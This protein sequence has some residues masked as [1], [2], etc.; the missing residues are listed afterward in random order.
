MFVLVRKVCN[1]LKVHLAINEINILY[2]K[3][4]KPDFYQTKRS[5]FGLISLIESD[6]YASWRQ[7]LTR[8][9]TMTTKSRCFKI[10]EEKFKEIQN[11]FPELKM[12]I[13]YDDE[14]VDLSMDIPKQDGVDFEINL[15]LQNEDELHLATAYIW[16][17]FFSADSEELVDKFYQSVIGL[18]N[19]EY[20]IL[21][22]VNG[23]KV[24]KTL[25]QKLNGLDWETI[26]TGYERWRM[27][28]TK[29]EKNVIQNRTESKLIRT[30]KASS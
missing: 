11:H 5:N 4:N 16:C 15:N 19:G 26:Y 1:K 10:A 9:N 6:L 18:I 8:N 12:I 25:L 27:P 24:Y 14:H 13:N 20:R 30:Y 3:I 2:L 17:Q 28:W 21:Q 29:V 7:A 22:F 23:D